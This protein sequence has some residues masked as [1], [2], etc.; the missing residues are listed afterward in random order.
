MAPVT[1]PL[2]LGFPSKTRSGVKVTMLIWPL[3]KDTEQAGKLA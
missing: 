3:Q 1:L 2:L